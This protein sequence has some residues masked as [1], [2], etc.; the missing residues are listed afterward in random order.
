[1]KVS[2]VELP[3]DDQS[4]LDPSWPGVINP[5]WVVDP[6][7]IR[8]AWIEYHGETWVVRVD[9][10]HAVLTL[11]GDHLTE[12][13]ALGRVR[14]LTGRDATVDTVDTSGWWACDRPPYLVEPARVVELHPA[15]VEG[16]GW[17]LRADM[18]GGISVT[19]IGSYPTE[20][21]ARHR[22]RELR[23]GLTA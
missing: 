16:V 20:A 19:L 5:P 1:M 7:R 21:E 17:V 8:R 3:V 2:E 9:V 6:A 11:T 15:L 10:G 12:R 22:A 18:I 14:E 23:P 4:T 13:D